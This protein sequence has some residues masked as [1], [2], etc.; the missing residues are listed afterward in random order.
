M[1]P[2][3]DKQKEKDVPA[4]PIPEPPAEDDVMAMFEGQKKKK[5]KKKVYEEDAAPEAAA[6]EPVEEVA[7]TQEVPQAP[8]AAPV[9]AKEEPTAAE[10]E[11]AFDFG[12]K[13]KK[14]KKAFKF[15]DDIAAAPA[16]DLEGAAP[17]ASTSEG[18]PAAAGGEA[19][20]DFGEK[21]KKKGKGKRPNL[22]DFEAQLR[23]EGGMQDEGVKE[24]KAGD[25]D[26]GKASGDPWIGSTRDYTY[27][28]L[29]ARV[30]AILKQNNP[31]LAGEVKKFVIVPPQVAREGTKKT[32]FAN[33]VDISKRM[34]REPDHLIQ[35]LFAE[36]GTTGSVDGSQRL[37]IKGRFQQKQIENVLK[38]YI[39]EYVTCKT[40][41]SG[42]TLLAK[43]NRL[44]FLQCQSCGS[45]KSVSA[46]KTGFLAQTQKRSAQRAA[47]GV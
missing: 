45:T 15:D 29:L 6:P 27:Q 2:K 10:E 37:V 18:A 9:T 40:C 41:K 46:I 35:Y 30:F 14:K 39:V 38:R 43:E 5:K 7:A 22:D 20:F 16:D 28:E 11:T 33:I 13:K 47:A 8:E 36:L 24:E 19:T 23:S 31:N 26:G 3:K 17:V 34:R 32:I 1:A 44:F 12:E 21:K 42:E 25:G 4:E